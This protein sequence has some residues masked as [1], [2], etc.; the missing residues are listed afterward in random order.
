MEEPDEMEQISPLEQ[1]SQIGQEQEQQPEERI[2]FIAP[3]GTV[4]T[5]FYEVDKRLYG[6]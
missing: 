4:S 5:E 1:S 3:D 2:L 6:R